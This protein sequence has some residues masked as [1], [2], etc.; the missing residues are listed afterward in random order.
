M[1]CFGLCLTAKELL[2]QAQEQIKNARKG[3][4]TKKQLELCKKAGNKIKDAEKKFKKAEVVDDALRPRFANAYHAHS[5]LLE[6]LGQEV[7]A[8]KSDDLAKTWGYVH[9][10]TDVPASVPEV[11]CSSSDRMI[12]SGHFSPKPIFPENKPSIA[13]FPF[14]ETDRPLVKTTQ[15]AYCLQLLR[16]TIVQGNG[17][18]KFEREWLQAKA[19][20][21]HE[22]ERLETLATDIVRA[23]VRDELK[24]SVAVKEVVCLST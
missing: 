22:V 4:T 18:D 15:L 14:P 19:K 21:S 13:K 12:D 9:P 17:I 2:E 1:G 3:D 23:F 7:E 16:T 11:P 24:D 10:T 6:E 8:R 20:E 5:M